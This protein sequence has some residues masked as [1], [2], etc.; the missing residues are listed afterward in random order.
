MQS[1]C[2]LQSKKSMCIDFNNFFLER[3][4]R[5]EAAQ[6]AR[7]EAEELAKNPVVSRIKHLTI[8]FILIL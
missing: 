8:N 6:K 1:K 5:R 3:V 2:F 4:K 7:L